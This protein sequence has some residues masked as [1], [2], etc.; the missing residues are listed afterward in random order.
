M[1]IGRSLFRNTP[2]QKLPGVSALYGRLVANAYGGSGTTVVT[3][4]GLEIEIPSGDITTLPS[5]ADGTYEADELDV[6]LASIRAGAVVA[7]IG[8]NIGIWS[9]LLSRAVGPNGRVVAFEPSPD[10]LTLLRAN[11]ARNGCTN[12]EIVPAA[13]GR[14]SGTASFETTTAGATHHLAAEGRSGDISVEVTTLDDFARTNAVGFDAIKVDIE[15]FEP[16]AF[17]GMTNVLDGRP[18]LLTEFSVAQARDARLVWDDTLAGLLQRY[19]SCDV[20][21]GRTRRRVEPHQADEILA[22]PKLLNLLFS[23]S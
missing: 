20:F 18:L 23:P 8:A 14:S 22:S 3:F 17:A 19:G 9:A 15:G 12:V 13:V 1:R 21:D 7:D 4:R 16:D 5:L 6:Y 10:N 11:L 2:L